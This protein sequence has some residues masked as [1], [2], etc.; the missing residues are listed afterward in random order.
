MC[1]CVIVCIKCTILYQSKVTST[2]LQFRFIG[3]G[4]FLFWVWQM[5]R[6]YFEREFWHTC[7]CKLE[8][9]EHIIASQSHTKYK[10][11]AQCQVCRLLG[12][13]KFY[14]FPNTDA[15]QNLC[16]FFGTRLF[17]LLPWQSWSPVFVNDQFAPRIYFLSKQS[18]KPKILPS[19][20]F[21]FLIFFCLLLEDT[22]GT[23]C[24]S[25]FTKC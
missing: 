22:L 19:L 24:I 13:P 5:W 14:F 2:N 7:L 12:Y 6:V 15:A 8:S 1:F 21:E 25:I 16:P 9:P 11:L 17:F 23:G 3:M 4:V 18:S 20:V 10:V